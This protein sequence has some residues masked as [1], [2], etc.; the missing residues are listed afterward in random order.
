MAIEKVTLEVGGKTLSIETGRVA[1]QADGSVWVQYGNTVVLVAAVA[2]AN[3]R[4]GQDF[5]PLT[6]D[7]REKTYAAGKI[8][9]GFFKREG[10]QKDSEI[11]TCRLIDRPLRPL[12]PE[13]FL[14]EVAV[15]AMVLSSDKENDSDIPAMIGASAA[16]AISD[17]PFQK[18]IGAVRIGRVAGQ[19]VI[20]PTFKQIAEGDVDIVVAA[21]KDAIMM[22]EGEANQI[23]EEEM[24]TALAMAHEECKKLVALQE[25]LV[26]RCGKPKSVFTLHTIDADLNKAVRA[27]AA[28]R[29]K[30]VNANADKLARQADLNKIAE[31]TQAEIAP[32]FEG[33]EKQIKA[34]LENIEVEMVR[35]MI[36]IDGKRPDGRA[37]DEIRPISI[38]TSVLPCTH[39]SA[40]FT[41]G[42]TQALVVSTL[43]TSDDQQL[44]EELE[45]E[46]WR[47]Y[48]LHY[49]FPSF[50]VGETKPNRGPGRRE[51][52]HGNLAER[53]I[54]PV[55]P[56]YDVFPY[57]I[58]IVSE[59][60]ESN[61]SSSMASVCGGALSLMDAGVPITAPVAGVAMG[62]IK[63][64]DK[65]VVLTDIQGLEDHF[66]DMDFKVAGSAKG[67]TAIQMDIKIEGVT[68]E[69]MTKALAQAL[70]G[71]MFILDKMSQALDAPRAEMSPYAPRIVTLKINKEKIGALIGQ[72]G[73]NIRGIEEDT[74][75]KVEVEDDGT[76]RVSS[77]DG[78][79]L[80]AA[81]K[82]VKD[83]VASAEVNKTYLGTVVKIIES[84]AFVNI[85]PNLDGFVH[86][87][88]LA[89][90]KTV[91]VEDVVREGDQIV[92]KCTEIDPKSGKV[93]LSR[94][95]A[96]VEREQAAGA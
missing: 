44:A 7:Y 62:L 42:Q 36:A 43:G 25:E 82:R 11:L 87:S 58:R 46:N 50:S 3:V 55:L 34:V 78:A 81:L 94:K 90:T 91:K 18:P 1:K 32:K 63:E 14:N 2:A 53:A 75:A 47:K 24:L 84:G 35:G 8:P 28:D 73:K 33:K 61:G 52:G 86:I 68:T 64:G 85:L 45:G 66:G 70:K 51:I 39:G 38:E 49:N 96:L 60:L 56:A 67:I 20:N 12:F 54:R 77:P 4:E 74:K 19:W 17:I 89:K 80:E 27:F 83:S 37:M 23:S 93:R 79:A 92:V 30:K 15:S 71:R 29:M 95:E 69:I 40:I 16:L 13:G 21:S 65:F 5:F 59:I 9:G 31:E 41:R 72:G 57:T 6:V 26:K 88:Q 48:F 76:V 10:K 22:V